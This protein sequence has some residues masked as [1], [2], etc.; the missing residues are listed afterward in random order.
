MLECAKINIQET[1]IRE[2]KVPKSSLLGADRST[3][4][5]KRD[6]KVYQHCGDRLAGRIITDK[7]LNYPSGQNGH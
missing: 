2:R 7:F 4:E 5:A 6:Y 3:L 1:R